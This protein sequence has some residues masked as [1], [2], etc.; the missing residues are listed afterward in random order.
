METAVDNFTTLIQEAGWHTTKQME[1]N[2]Y[3][4][5]YPKYILSKIK[6][7]ASVPYGSILEL[8]LHILY[9]RPISLLHQIHYSHLPT[10]FVDTTILAI[11][12]DPEKASQIIQTYIQE[13]EQWTAHGLQTYLET[14]Y[15]Q[16]LCKAI[17]KPIWIYGIQLMTTKSH[18]QKLESLQAI[19]L[20]TVVNAPW[21]IC[22][23]EICKDLNMLSVSD[24][25]GRRLCENYKN[26]DQH[27]NAT[28]KELYS[29][30]QPRRLCRKYSIDLLT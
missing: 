28:A 5:S 30:N 17:I 29:F 6:Q 22:N 8:T 1:N 25:I 24:E 15:I 10:T 16:L 23:D 13:L 26:L 12:E 27:P 19:I 11:Y 21:Y 4:N 20:K 18:I 14:T 9:T 2:H 3:K 7:K